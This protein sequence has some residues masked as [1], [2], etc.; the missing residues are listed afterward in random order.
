M[1]ALVLMLVLLVVQFRSVVQPLLIF[2]AIP[3]SFFGVFTPSASANPISFF[4][5]VGFIALI[6]VVVN[7]TILLVDAAGQRRRLR[8]KSE[9]KRSQWRSAACLS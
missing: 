7:N 8:S 1:I 4:V 9:N 3:F 2:L 5:A 6:G